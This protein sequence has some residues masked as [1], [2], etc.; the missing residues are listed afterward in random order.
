MAEQEYEHAKY[1]LNRLKKKLAKKTDSE[2]QIKLSTIST[3]SKT[4]RFLNSIIL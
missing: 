3:K 1:L 2:F 4:I